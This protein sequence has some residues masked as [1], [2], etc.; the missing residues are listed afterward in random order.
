[1]SVCG[2]PTWL[3]ACSD[4]LE[5]IKQLREHVN[6]DLEARESTKII[7]N[8]LYL[9]TNNNGVKGIIESQQIWFTHHKHLNDPGELRFGM[10]VARSLS[11][12]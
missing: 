8:Q 2:V 1:M 5:T 3:M 11:E 10:N 9:Y 7:S 12:N 4:P 6:A